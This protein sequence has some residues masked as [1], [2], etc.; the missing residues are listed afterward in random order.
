MRETLTQLK[1]A[2]LQ[3]TDLSRPKEGK[4][5]FLNLSVAVEALNA[6]PLRGNIDEKSN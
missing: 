5:L 1:Q 4:V 3:S 6:N 2:L